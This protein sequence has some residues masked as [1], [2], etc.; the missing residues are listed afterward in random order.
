MCEAEMLVCH[1]CD[2]HGTGCGTTSSYR[3]DEDIQA[4]LPR[5]QGLG[6]FAPSCVFLVSRPSLS[7]TATTTSIR[8][9]RQPAWQHA[10]GKRQD[11]ERDEKREEITTP[12]GNTP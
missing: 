3:R 4:N 2:L 11:I 7:H 9:P 8:T 10:R 6:A 1:F 5:A 12:K